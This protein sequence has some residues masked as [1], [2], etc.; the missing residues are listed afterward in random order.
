MAS[1]RIQAAIDYG[2]GPDPSHLYNSGY[3]AP[4]AGAFWYFGSY[5]VGI[6]FH[7]KQ[8]RINFNIDPCVPAGLPVGPWFD[9]WIAQFSDPLDLWWQNTVWPPEC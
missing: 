7:N 1:D 3:Y 2:A 4:Q 6:R 9:Q 8:V 5:V